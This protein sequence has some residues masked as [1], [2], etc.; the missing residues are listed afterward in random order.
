[1]PL[2][3]GGSTPNHKCHLKFPFWLFA[4]LPKLRCS[5]HNNCPANNH[6]DLEIFKSNTLVG[7]EVLTL[8]VQQIFQTNTEIRKKI[9]VGWG[10]DWLLEMGLARCKLQQK[11][12]QNELKSFK[13]SCYKG[14]WYHTYT[15][16]YGTWCDIAVKKISDNEGDMRWH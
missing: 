8:K 14:I 6:R 3:R 9:L 12:R 4:H 7:F 15:R 13:V 11:Q 5:L 16:A 10:G 2:R 1:M